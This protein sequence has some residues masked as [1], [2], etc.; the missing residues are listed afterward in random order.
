MGQNCQFHQYQFIAGYL[1]GLKEQ[2]NSFYVNG[3]T[4]EYRLI[5][6]VYYSSVFSWP[7]ALGVASIHQKV[8]NRIVEPYC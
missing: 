4:L 5:D 8:N 7:V 3:N 1:S 2:L 6:R